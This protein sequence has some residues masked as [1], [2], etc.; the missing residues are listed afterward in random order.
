[1]THLYDFSFQ[2][3][4]SKKTLPLSQFKEKTIL[5][6]NTASYCG[7]TPQY[8]ELQKLWEQY[9]DKNFVLI[10]VPCNDFGQQEPKSNSEIYD[11]CKTN[12]HVDFLL[13]EKIHIKGQEAHPFFQWLSHEVV[14]FWG[15]PR[16][17]FYKYLFSPHG[18]LTDWFFPFTS[19]LS[20]KLTS[21]IDKT[22][23]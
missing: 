14:S 7:F 4:G 6:I 17:N 19:P 23:Q 22:Y 18:E 13:T 5:I 16:W 20:T 2:E 11:F 10:G 1:M 21:L 9:K 3:S 15:Q 12:F 8:H